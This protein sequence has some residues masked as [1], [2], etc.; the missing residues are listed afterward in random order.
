MLKLTYNLAEEL[1]A[2]PP[3]GSPLP[4]GSIFTDH[5]FR[6]DYT[7]EKGWH[8]PRI[9]PYGPIELEPSCTVFH[10]AQAMFEGMKAYR[11]KD[12]RVLLFRPDKNAERTNRTNDRICIP[13][14]P[15]EDYIQAVSELVYLERDWIPQQPDS[16]LYIRPFIIA[17]DPQH[18]LRP[19]NTYSFMIILCP[20]GPYYP[21][22]LNPVK[23]WIEDEY[24]RAVRGGIGEAKTGGNYV[25]S[26][27]AQVKAQEAGYSQVLWLDGV[28]R[29]YIEEVGAM[30]IMFK[31]DD[32]I[33]TP[34]LNGSILPGVTR[35]SVLELCR[36]WDLP[37]EERKITVDELVD[38]CRTGKLQECF[39][40]GTAA[41]ISP[42]GE[43]R[44]GDEHFVIN[45]GE[46]GSFSQKLYDTITGIQKGELEGPPGWSFEVKPRT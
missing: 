15:P 33:V 12:G 9:L 1:K 44:Y 28:E 46:I 43:L 8:D 39:G 40:T 16:S 35:D 27:K 32:V 26:L 5:M 24:V 18:G 7:P 25:A 4:F 19:S 37:V 13:Y 30:N 17:T 42:V 45:N 10:Y 36:S 29:H 38:A 23:I 3:V 6:M 11:A 2:K 20:V 31:I 21:E 34:E 41:V 22:G 14:L